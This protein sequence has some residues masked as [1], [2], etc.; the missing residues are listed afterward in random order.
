M[1]DFDFG[2]LWIDSCHQMIRCHFPVIDGLSFGKHSEYIFF[3]LEWFRWRV[4]P[5]HNSKTSISYQNWYLLFCLKKKTQFL[6]KFDYANE[7]EVYGWIFQNTRRAK[8]ITQRNWVP[9][10]SLSKTRLNPYVSNVLWNTPFAEHVL[11][12]SLILLVVKKVSNKLIP[13]TKVLKTEYFTW[14]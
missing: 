12:S 4:A 13:L 6:Q 11:I 8:F 1:A 5:T 3:H 14:R 10:V 7:I 9:R 2:N